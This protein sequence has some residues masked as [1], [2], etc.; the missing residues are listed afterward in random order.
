[1]V[2]HLT[3]PSSEWGESNPLLLGPK[4]SDLPL[5][6]IPMSPM[7]GRY[8]Q[9]FP[10]PEGALLY[11]TSRFND[12]DAIHL[13]PTAFTVRESNPC[14]RLVGITGF[15]PATSRSQSARSTK[16]SYIPIWILCGVINLRA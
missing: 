6:H 7:L 5:A 14:F 16:L 13:R 4:P 10:L 8:A 15:E 12:D 11:A 3:F 2:H 1:M 9:V